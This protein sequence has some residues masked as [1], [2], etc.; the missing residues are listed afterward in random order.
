M[1]SFRNT[2]ALLLFT[3]LAVSFVFAAES[4][5]SVSS[6]V[7][8]QVQDST[9]TIT[10]LDAVILPDSK[11]GVRQAVDVPIAVCS[12]GKPYPDRTASSLLIRPTALTAEPIRHRRPRDGL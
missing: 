1:V 3:V 8:N 12:T 11:S 2:L 10:T 6:T 4:P 9:T 5:P 7:T